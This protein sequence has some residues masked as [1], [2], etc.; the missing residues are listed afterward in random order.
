MLLW[1]GFDDSG[2]FTWGALSCGSGRCFFAGG[3]PDV[4][5]IWSSSVDDVVRL[6]PYLRSGVSWNDRQV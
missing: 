1:D 5:G 6:V 2:D 3:R 4:E